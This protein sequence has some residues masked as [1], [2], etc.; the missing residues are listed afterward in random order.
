MSRLWLARHGLATGPGDVGLAED[1]R[2]QAALLGERLVGAGITRINHS[3]LAR[4]VETAAIVSA[5]LPGVPVE[6]AAELD[7]IDPS[8]DPAASDAMVARFS[9]RPADEL[10]IT[11]NFQV[12]WFLRAALEA[13]AE[14][15]VGL[16]SCNTGVTVL[17]SRPGK[18]P[19]PL[20][21][22]D[23]THLPPEL[24]WTGFPPELSLP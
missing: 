22:N 20:V 18:K 9:D 24:R 16:N 3:P 1:G 10:C 7:D 5:A 4:A 14:R 12:A 19:H 6:V 23:V 11:H 8:D 17:R 2:R 15:W 13:P 21:F